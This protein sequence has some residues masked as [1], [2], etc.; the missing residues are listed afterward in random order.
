[1]VAAEKKAEENARTEAK[2]ETKAENA[3]NRQAHRDDIA[4]EHQA[5]AD[6]R[7]EARADAAA[8]K[9]AKEAANCKRQRT[10]GTRCSTNIKRLLMRPKRR[11]GKR[12]LLSIR[13]MMR[14]KRR[15]GKRLLIRRL[16]SRT[17]GTRRF[18]NRRLLRRLLRSRRRLLRRPWRSRS[19]LLR[20]PLKRW[21]KILLPRRRRSPPPRRRTRR[22]SAPLRRSSAPVRR[23]AAPEL[24]KRSSK[25][26]M[27]C[28]LKMWRTLACRRLMRAS[29]S[30]R[31]C[32]RSWLRHRLRPIRRC[33]MRSSN[34]TRKR[35]LLSRRPRSRTGRTE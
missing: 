14:P 27:P 18:A 9:E 29:P 21:R 32:A 5:N 30:W 23:R 20:Q 8:I 11:E 17:P 3:A 31:L 12:L 4:A 35:E 26:R 28:K 15:E 2:E 7:E 16:R 19:L 22:S 13:R 34:L 10:P 24:P 33:G 1:M 25:S 6:A